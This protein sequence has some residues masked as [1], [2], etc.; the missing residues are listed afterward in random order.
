MS[1]TNL[2]LT[3]IGALALLL[4]FTSAPLLGGCGQKDEPVD[5]SDIDEDKTP[6]K[7]SRDAGSDAAKRDAK[8]PVIDEGDDDEVDPDQDKQPEIKRDA[9]APP[10]T[11]KN[12][13]WCKAKAVLESRC[14]SCHDGNGTA[15]TPTDINFAEHAD[16]MTESPDVD[17]AMMFQRLAVRIHPETSGLGPMPPKNPLTA[18]QIADLDA[19]VAAGAPQASDC[20]AAPAPDGKV[21]PDGRPISIWDPSLCDDIYKLTVPALKVPASPQETYRQVD[22]DA[23]WGS[24]QVQIINTRPITDNGPVLHHWILYDKKGP[25]LTGWAPGDDE[26]R[27]MPKDVGMKVPSGPASMYLDLHYYNRTGKEQVDSSGVEVCVVK[28]KNLRANPSGVTM[29]FSQLAFSIP[30][31]A[32]EHSV[33]G[34]C[35]VRASKPIHIMTASPHAHRLARRTV[36][37]VQKKN[38]TKIQMLD[39]KFTFGEQASFPLDEEVIVES[40]DKIVTECIFANDGNQAVTFGESNDSEMCF[41]FASYYPVGSFCCEELGLESCLLGG[42]SGVG[43]GGLSGLDP[44]SIFGG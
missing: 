21:G 33:K 9:G 10:A 36:F 25:F 1:Q 17:G 13:L 34:T 37:T 40:G 22:L 4:S 26:R 18:Q 24:E 38:G 14:T 7:T 19:W 3:G 23:P 2:R 5:D 42:G 27:P 20:A 32:T 43:S 31:G 11:D 35:T 15:G 16:L 6:V 44:S 8:A 39:E 28:G 12:G 29:G 30:P 41:N